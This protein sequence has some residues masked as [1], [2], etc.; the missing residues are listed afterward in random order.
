MHTLEVGQYRSTAVRYQCQ[1]HFSACMLACVCQNFSLCAFVN[2]CQCLGSRCLVSLMS[3]VQGL[4]G[5]LGKIIFSCFAMKALLNVT[6]ETP[7]NGEGLGW[8]IQHL[9]SILA[10]PHLDTS[11]D[12]RAYRL[13]MGMLTIPSTMHFWPCGNMRGCVSMDMCEFAT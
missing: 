6:E 11:P 4:H 2:L 12:H 8:I 7:S 3:G 13:I 5:G 9:Q 1:Q 10:P